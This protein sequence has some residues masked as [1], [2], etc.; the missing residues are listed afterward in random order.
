MSTLNVCSFQIEKYSVEICEELSSSIQ[1]K[2]FRVREA[3]CL[4][5]T[6]FASLLYSSKCSTYIVPF[7]THVITRCDDIKVFVSLFALNRCSQCW[8]QDSVREAAEK[9]LSSLSRAAI[10]NCGP[11]SLLGPKEK[12]SIVGIVIPAL[13]SQGL[14]SRFSLVSN[15]R[16]LLK[17]LNFG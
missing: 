12:S 9:A 5:L 7:W 4:A 17:I 16:L 2:E 6:D 13:V 3:A 10:R 11:D 8:L 1:H 15:T 14:G